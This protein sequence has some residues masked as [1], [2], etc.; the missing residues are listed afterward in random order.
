MAAKV[1]ITGLFF[2]YR[3]RSLFKL[4]QWF[5]LFNEFNF[6]VMIREDIPSTKFNGEIPFSNFSITLMY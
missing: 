5:K 4:F 6:S 3:R 2:V 1:I